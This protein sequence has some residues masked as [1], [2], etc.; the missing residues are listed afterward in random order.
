MDDRMNEYVKMANPDGQA[1]DLDSWTAIDPYTGE[2]Y[3]H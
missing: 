1:E 3:K 2:I